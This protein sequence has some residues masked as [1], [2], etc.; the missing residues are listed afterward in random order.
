MVGIKWGQFYHIIKLN[1][2]RPAVF[3]QESYS[4]LQFV[5]QNVTIDKDQIV[6]IVNVHAINVVFASILI[7]IF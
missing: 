6:L 5:F 4:I 7:L 3:P 1:D 2:T